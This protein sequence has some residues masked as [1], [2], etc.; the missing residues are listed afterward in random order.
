[1][2]QRGHAEFDFFD[3]KV[4]QGRMRKPSVSLQELRRNN[5]PKAEKQW[6]FWGL[7]VHVTKPETLTAAYR[8]AK[9]ND[10]TPGIDGE[11]FQSI[12][13]RGVE[14]F[15]DEIRRELLSGTYEPSKN[16]R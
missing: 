8:E 14:K 3:R 1:M 9:A 10:G 6:R 12:E 7:Y 4:R 11:S 5:I 15:L 13:I 2:E 16:R